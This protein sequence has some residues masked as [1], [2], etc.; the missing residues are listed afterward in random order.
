MWPISAQGC[1]GKD[2]V[3]TA[4]LSAMDFS[5]RGAIERSGKGSRAHVQ[6]YDKG[7][8]RNIPG[9][10]RPDEEAAKEDLQ[11]MRA[12]A[13]GMNR[14]DG[15]AA[16]KAEADA[17]K[18]GKPP[19]EVGV[20]ERDGNTFRAH[21]QYRE[22]GAKQHIPGPWRPDE[23]A[24]KTDLYAMRAAANGM[25]REDGFAA[26]KVE[27]DRLKA[28]KV[29]KEQGSVKPLGKSFAALIRWTDDEGEE[30]RAYG[31]RRTEKR[32]AEEDLECMRE[33]SSRHSDV[34]SRRKAVDVEVRRLKQQAED[35][36][37]VA[38]VARRLSQE[39]R[40]QEQAVEQRQQQ[41]YLQRQHPVEYDSDSQ[42]DW[43]PGEADDADVVY[44]WER[45]DDRGRPLPEQLQ[46]ARVCGTYCRS[47]LSE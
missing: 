15:F 40:Q 38:G 39:Q 29:P 28:G 42:S 11:S 7:A 46:A 44:A 21:V 4:A 9:P 30:R 8:N 37:R 43:E 20:V 24:A 27:A 36:V 23:E 25:S 3:W 26:M 32:R 31:P 19:K 41:P 47:N 16:M 35:E 33:A 10:W 14:E 12:A 2:P 17:L 1:V 5:S 13:S 6:W 34:L 22:Q 18:A 45:F